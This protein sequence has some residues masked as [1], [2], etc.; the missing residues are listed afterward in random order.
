MLAR[1]IAHLTGR[2]SRR[3]LSDPAASE[4]RAAP[5]VAV[6]APAQTAS[7][8][9]AEPSPASAWHLLA[10]RPAI[11]AAGA[12]AG[13]ELRLSDWAVQRLARAGVARALQDTYG[14]ALVQAA[15]SV[16]DSGRRPLVSVVGLDDVGP[17][18]AALPRGSIVLVDDGSGDP[19]ARLVQYIHQ[20]HAAGLS[21]AVPP[22]LQDKVPADYA[23]LD[24][25][26]LGS[27]EVLRRC[28]QAA[29]APRG[30]IAMNL[31]SFDEVAEAVNQRAALAFGRLSPARPAGA[32]RSTQPPATAAQVAAILTALVSGRP[33][34]EI[35][36]MFKADV[37]LSYRLLRYLSM[38]GV[39]HG[40]SPTTIQ[41]ALLMLGTRE[42]HRW[43]CVLLADCGSSPIA[44]ALHETALT[45]GRLLEM[46][47]I[48]RHEPNPEALFVLGAFS[49]LDQLLDVPLEAALALA[50]VPEATID[51]LIA[52]RGPWRSYLEVALALEACDPTRLEETCSGLRLTRDAVIAMNSEAARWSTEAVSSLREELR[53]P[54]RQAAPATA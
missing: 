28:R 31:G 47:A 3:P 15:R 30:W 49:L 17:I 35:A 18:L 25:A 11:D 6:E 2:R 21:T 12:I 4:G 1:F 39:G 40:H 16:A 43:L 44:R 7:T 52:E 45:R 32:R 54:R 13:W 27:A 53:Q 26:R 41:A 23:L 5:P 14:Y 9:P 20:M 51:A 8:P 38:A 29:Q 19:A 34:R 37:T 42:L 48:E 33:P 10:R 22:A 46:M 50:P 36:E 24:A